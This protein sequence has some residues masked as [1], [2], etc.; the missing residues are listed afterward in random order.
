MHR[1]NEIDATDA[2]K[3]KTT[4]DG[5]H[6]NPVLQPNASQMQNR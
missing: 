1:L 3:K 4:T 6:Q 5:I 2:V